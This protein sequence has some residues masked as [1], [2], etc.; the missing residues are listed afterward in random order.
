L[1]ALRISTP[2]EEAP[3]TDVPL[4]RAL[5]TEYQVAGS[6]LALR[7]KLNDAARTRTTRTTEYLTRSPNTDE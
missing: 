1:A 2:F 7:V 6:P 5:H 3:P 4:M